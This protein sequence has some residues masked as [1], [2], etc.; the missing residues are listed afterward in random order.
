MAVTPEFYS[1]LSSLMLLDPGNN[2]VIATLDGNLYL[3]QGQ[4]R[5]D[6]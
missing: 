3:L 2:D 6:R 4:S 1:G 5:R